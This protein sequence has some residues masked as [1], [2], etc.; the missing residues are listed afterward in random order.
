VEDEEA[1]GDFV[2][3]RRWVV[4]V[5]GQR[6]V[7]G[8]LGLGWLAHPVKAEPVGLE[9]LPVLGIHLF[10]RREI[11]VGLVELALLVEAQPRVVV[12]GGGGRAGEDGDPEVKRQAQ[13]QTGPSRPGTLHRPETIPHCF[14]PPGF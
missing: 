5:E 4:R 14:Q 7:A 1:A 3:S 9:G 12:I 8:R 10:R 6:L 13:H 11:A 2:P